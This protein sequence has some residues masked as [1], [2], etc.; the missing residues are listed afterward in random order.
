MQLIVGDKRVNVT[1]RA[2]D[3]MI[4][5]IALK[6]EGLLKAGLP[7]LLYRLTEPRRSLCSLSEHGEHGERA[8]VR[9]DRHNDT[10]KVSEQRATNPRQT[11][12][13]HQKTNIPTGTTQ[14]TVI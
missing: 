13:P 5:I 7:A 8:T 10:P 4:V 9:A 1:V 11:R 12:I 2:K 3:A 6:G 14:S